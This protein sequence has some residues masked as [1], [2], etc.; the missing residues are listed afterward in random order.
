MC[1]SDLPGL[2]HGYWIVDILDGFGLESVSALGCSLGGYVLL[3]AAQVAPERIGRAALW[4]PGG[5]IKPSYSNMFG[6]I[7]A[8][9]MYSLRPTTARLERMLAPMFT[10]I[11]DEYV[12]FMGDSLAHVHPDRRFPATLPDG[13]LDAWRA[14]V[15]LITHELDTVFPAGD[16]ERRAATLIPNIERSMRVPGARH[17]P[18]FDQTHLATITDPLVDFLEG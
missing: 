2:E 14:P 10:D 1:S 15:M 13:A 6:L 18:P 8:G 3:R 11:D 17:M 7:G 5:V 16:V 12:A 4:V 9:I